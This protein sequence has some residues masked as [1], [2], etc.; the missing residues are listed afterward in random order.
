MRRDEGRSGR[1][2]SVTW[3]GNA[4]FEIASP[5]VRIAVDPWI[6]GNP[7][8]SLDL[9]DFRPGRA[10]HVFVTHGH[11]GHWGRGDS[12]D[13]AA[14]CAA[15]LYAP[16]PLAEYIRRTRGAGVAVREVGDG[17][18]MHGDVFDATYRVCPHPEAPALSSE[19]AVVPCE[20][21]GFY[22][23]ALGETTVIHVGDCVPDPVFREL[24]AECP[25]IDLACLPLWGAGMAV[26]REDALRRF[27]EV[28]DML[29]PARVM[30]HNR[31]DPERRAWN[32]VRDIFTREFPRV[33][34]LPQRLDEPE[35]LP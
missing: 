24:A 30:C 8:C 7:G 5:A 15:P 32:A 16:E 27:L 9:R 35:V 14:A 29:R 28:V 18:T 21:N 1:R 2:V 12:A 4:F 25:R 33:V 20:P 19:D 26:S 22:R 34:L 11:P 13:I 31:F 6:R 17:W 23:F 3:R 10:T